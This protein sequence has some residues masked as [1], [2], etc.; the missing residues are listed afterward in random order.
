MADATHDD[1]TWVERAN[2]GDAE[3]FERL[4]EAHRQWVLALATRFTGNR[5]DA[6]D[7]LQESFADLFSRFP[8]FR[9]TSTLRAYLYPVVKHRSMSLLRRRRR[10][11]ALEGVRDL[12]PDPAKALTWFVDTPG[13]FDRLIEALPLG[14]REVVRLRFALDLRLHEIA[15]ALGI[16]LGTV[17][18]RLHLALA[19][20]REKSGKEE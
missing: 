11:I 8:G 17:K 18:S 19:A 1:Q 3:G 9:L 2:A 10:T 12:G 4:F 15:E 16:P 5:E 7:V 13:D 6:L 20:L 14:Q